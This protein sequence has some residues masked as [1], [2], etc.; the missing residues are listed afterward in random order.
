MPKGYEWLVPPLGVTS[1]WC[2]VHGFL[3]PGGDY[4]W[5]CNEIAER[6]FVQSGGLRIKT[7][8]KYGEY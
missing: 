4:T 6:E 1:F 2:L 8:T 7:V 3:R 5:L